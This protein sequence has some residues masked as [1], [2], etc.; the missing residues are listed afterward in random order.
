M[1][2]RDGL[3]LAVTDQH[4]HRG[5]GECAPL[6]GY[7]RE[8]LDEAERQL[9]AVARRILH[10]EIVDIP[11]LESAAAICGKEA[12]SSVRFAVESALL[13]LEAVT[14][15][16]PVA[17]V[18]A[19]DFALSVA[20]NA[21]VESSDNLSSRLAELSVH[22]CR[23]AKLKV[24]RQTLAED[25]EMVKRVRES[26]SPDIAL[27]LDAN[28][29]WTLDQATRFAEG[30]QGCAIEYIEE[31]L[32]DSS[33]LPLLHNVFPELPLAIDESVRDM[34][35]DSIR[36][37][38]HITAVV[39]KPT[40]GGGIARSL[41]IVRACRQSGKT[42][43]LGA[44]IESSLALGMIAQMAASLILDIPI[45]LDTA[46]LFSRDLISPSLE[47]VDYAIDIDQPGFRMGTLNEDVIEEVPLG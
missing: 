47:L 19:R 6:L 15:D 44:A 27:R 20:I 18:L 26:L 7:S 31:P 1:T 29:A 37:A 36:E 32:R 9:V 46:R 45:G 2:T 39:I 33:E 40:V 42:P 13:S 14:L 24:G 5:L 22:N 3:V 21:L 28:R 12:A 10:S 38:E 11:P 25:I 34:N 43:V 16:Q 8:S 23:A 4:G 17:G 41:A 35:I 30:I